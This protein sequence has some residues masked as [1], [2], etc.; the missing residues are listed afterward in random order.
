MGIVY[1]IQ[2]FA[3]F[4]CEPAY[5]TVIPT[6]EYNLISTWGWGMKGGHWSFSFYSVIIIVVVVVVVVIII[7]IIIIII[8][9][10]WWKL[11]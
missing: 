10:S 7:I 3:R 11:L 6:W 8:P 5:F 9:E 1:L 4:W 2:Q